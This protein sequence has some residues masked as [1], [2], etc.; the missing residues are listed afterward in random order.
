MKVFAQH[1]RCPDANAN[2][3]MQAAGIE[4]AQRAWKARVIATRPRL[5]GARSAGPGQRCSDRQAQGQAPRCAAV[6]CP[7]CGAALPTWPRACDAC[8]F[9]LVQAP[10]LQAPADLAQPAPG[11]PVAA[12]AT[13]PAPPP[14]GRD[15]RTHLVVGGILA[16][17]ST[18]LPF[19]GIVGAAL[20][21][22]VYARGTG[23]QRTQGLVVAVAGIVGLAIGVAVYMAAC[24]LP[25][26]RSI[27]VP[28]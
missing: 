24:N 25:N 26:L 14:P 28:A 20:G 6:H 3:G 5:R 8:G 2:A 17:V 21:A 4:P 22:W 1:E 11:V 19:V 18:L 13:L 9:E 27:C 10:P 7:R 16:F 23:A 15:Y 12:H